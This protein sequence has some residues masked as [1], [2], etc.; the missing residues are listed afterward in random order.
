M[1]FLLLALVA[2]TD[3]SAVGQPECYTPVPEFTSTAWERQTIYHDGV[4]RGADGVDVITENGQPTVLSPW[5]QSNKLTL[6]RR[7]PDGSWVT[8]VLSLPSGF[9]PEGAAFGDYDSD[10]VLDVSTCGDAS[11]RLRVYWGPTYSTFTDVAAATGVQRWLVCGPASDGTT[12]VAGGRK[13]SDAPNASI[14]YFTATDPRSA[15]GWTYNPIGAVGLTWTLEVRGGM[16]L[17]ADGGDL[18]GLK[19]T[20]WLALE[21][22]GWVNHPI[23]SLGGATG[24]VKMADFGAAS[25]VDGAYSSTTGNHIFLRTTTDWTDWTSVELPTPTNVGRYHSAVRGDVVGDAE[26]DYVF[27]FTHADGALAGVVALDGATL[28]YTDISGPD[29]VKYDDAVL[30]DLEGD[31]DLDVITSEHK[32]NTA[33]AAEQLGVIA[34]I[35]PRVQ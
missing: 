1:R 23:A 12:L 27:T 5:E 10:G 11:K 8:Q 35:N 33:P 25:V 9:A 4:L 32:A 24:L 29:G 7:Q 19:G 34:Y 2:C 14:G 20:R 18:P 6:S 16:V 15:T 22:S 21:E 17:V 30:Y 13:T 3:L 26:D 28:E 31:G